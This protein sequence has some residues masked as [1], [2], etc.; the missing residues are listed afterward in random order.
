MCMVP[1]VVAA[2]IMMM[3]ETVMVET[4]MIETVM[5]PIEVVKAAKC[6]ETI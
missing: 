2:K 3:V 5:V 1:V 4:P 6:E